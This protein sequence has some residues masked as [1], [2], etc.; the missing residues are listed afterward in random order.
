MT[1]IEM[2]L[3]TSN[4]LY[5]K[6]GYIEFGSSPSSRGFLILDGK[7]TPEWASWQE[8]LC[9]CDLFSRW[10][11]STDWTQQ[12]KASPH[13]Y[14]IIIIPYHILSYLLLLSLGGVAGGL[15]ISL[16]LFAMYTLDMLPHWGSPILPKLFS[17]PKIQSIQKLVLM[18][19][20]STR[21]PWPVT[22]VLIKAE[23]TQCA[24]KS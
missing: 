11:R 7:L 20:C 2:N 24:R 6:A 15:R 14:L 23:C 4:Y 21:G 18:Q 22:P 1:S 10:D 12:I 17:N 3:L 8:Q 16:A 9:W 5:S 13:P 19:Y